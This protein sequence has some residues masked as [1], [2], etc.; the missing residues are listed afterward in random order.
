MQNTNN[1]EA[2]V[3]NIQLKFDQVVEQGSDQDLFVAG[4]LSGHFSLV[5]SQ[6]QLQGQESIEALNQGML[7]SLDKAFADGELEETDQSD[8]KAFW[9]NCL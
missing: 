7:A 3:D 1:F 9:A 8:V 5:V 6:C 4:Y 2:L